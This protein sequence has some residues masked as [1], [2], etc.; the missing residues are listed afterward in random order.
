MKGENDEKG[1]WRQAPL[2]TGCGAL[3]CSRMQRYRMDQHVPQEKWMHK[4]FAAPTAC[5]GSERLA[6]AENSSIKERLLL[7]M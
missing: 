2:G 3:L 4:T 1:D 6:I 5:A 7:R